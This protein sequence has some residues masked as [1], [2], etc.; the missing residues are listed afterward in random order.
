MPVHQG[1]AEPPGRRRHRHGRGDLARRRQGGELGEAHR[2]PVR[3][4]GDQP[5]FDRRPQDPHGGHRRFRAGRAKCSTPAL[6]ERLA[7]MVAEE[8]I[9]EAGIGRR[10]DFP[11]PLFLAVPPIEVEWHA[12]HRGGGRRARQ[13][14]GRLRRSA[15]GVRRRPIRDAASPLPARLGCQQS[16]RHVRHQRLADLAVDRLR[17]RRD[18]DPARRRGDPARRRRRG[19]VHRHRRLGQPGIA[20]PLFA[21][22]RAVHVQRRSGGSRQAVLQEPRRLRD[23]RRRRRG[24][25]G[26]PGGGAGARRQ[27]PRRGR[28]LRRDGGRVPSHTLEPG[29]QADH[30]LHPQRA[31]TT[32]GSPRTT[33]TTSTRTAP[34]RRRT[35][36]WKASASPPYS[37]S[38]PAAFRSRRTSP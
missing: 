17:I 23:G 15:A 37:A 9:S 25:A 31:S 5:V 27:D 36:R 22:L 8:A 32:P 7:D 29:R 1:Q 26:K 38:A 16:R 28:R 35:T 13:R 20:D 2:R 19:A 10:G 3:R 6:S 21:A 14:R 12:A 34:A 24:R 4:E 33:S 11:G 30:R 18:R